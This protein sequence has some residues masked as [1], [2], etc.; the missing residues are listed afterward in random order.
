MNR[1]DSEL[2]FTGLNFVAS[3]DAQAKR[4]AEEI[5]PA[6]I[7]EDQILGRIDSRV[8]RANGVCSFPAET[9]EEL[10][11]RAEL[12]IEASKDAC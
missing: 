9:E 8:F 3:H 1:A 10:M 2:V 6:R 5:I 4:F 11:I 12:M 7:D